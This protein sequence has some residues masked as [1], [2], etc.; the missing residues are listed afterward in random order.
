[1]EAKAVEEGFLLAR[2]LGPK[3][4]IVEGVALTVIKT[5]SIQD[6]PPS[7]I[8]KVIEGSKLR[9]RFFQAWKA[10]HVN[11]DCNTAAHMLAR[12][13]MSVSDCIFWMENT[14][15]FISS[16]VCKDVPDM[17]FSPQLMKVILH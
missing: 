16:Q 11:R 15:P 13:A 4:V 14:P 2:D 10:S 8:R 6:L 3:E 12:H 7:S 17:G 1:M 9:L 5:L